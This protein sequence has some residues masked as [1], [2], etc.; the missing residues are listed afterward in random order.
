MPIEFRCPQCSKLLRTPDD[1]AG[2]K[3]RCP[4]CGHVSAIPQPGAAPSGPAADAFP[5]INT[6]GASGAGAGAAPGA[7]QGGS[8]GPQPAGPAPSG[9]ALEPHPIDLNDIFQTGWA[10]FKNT[11]VP[12]LVGM[13][14]V[15]VASMVGVF[16]AVLGA[17][18]V[19]AVLGEVL[20]FLFGMFLFIGVAL[21]MAW[22]HAGQLL[23]F[24]KLVRQGNAEL[25]DLF[26]GGPYLI[27]LL[28]TGLIVGLAV[29][30]GMLLL[31]VPGIFLAIVFSQAL[32]V[33]VDR[34]VGPGEA[35]KVS[36]DITEGS[37][38]MLFVLWLLIAVATSI[39][40]ALTA[41]L[42]TLITAP[43]LMVLQPIVY[44][45]LTGQE[46]PHYE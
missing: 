20:G 22:L 25:G 5:G 15:M 3:A 45:R 44:L 12:A 37:R 27:S 46:I 6:S 23:Y 19:A 40:N 18:A 9:Q 29:S 34:N 38:L 35:L 33:V 1:A 39:L 32:L 4:E 28:I 43:F 24:L 26:T 2:R 11:L 7:G 14:V 16:A 8:F 31:I 41:G 42:A 13:L 30:F 21:F 36:W 17:T 10:V